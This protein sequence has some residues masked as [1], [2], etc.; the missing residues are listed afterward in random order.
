MIRED[1]HVWNISEASWPISIK[2][3]I[4]HHWDG[5]KAALGFGAD[6]IRTGFHGIDL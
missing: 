5:G 6:L 1:S 3:Y 2:F 4:K